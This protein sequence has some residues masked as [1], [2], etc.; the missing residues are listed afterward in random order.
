MFTPTFFSQVSDDFG[1]YQD[2]VRLNDL[3]PPS[4]GPP[5]N[6]SVSSNSTRTKHASGAKNSP[7]VRVSTLI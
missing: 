3:G 1:S 5:S 4:N 7:K 6:E 2:E